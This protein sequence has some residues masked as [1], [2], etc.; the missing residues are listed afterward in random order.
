MKITN[1]KKFMIEEGVN[2]ID[3]IVME[4]SS[5]FY[6]SIEAQ[7][8]MKFNAIKKAFEFHYKHSDFYKTYCRE[9]GNITPDDIQSY[10]DLSKIPVIPNSFFQE[11]RSEAMLSLP[12]EFK[13]LEFHTEG[14]QGRHG[15]AYRD[16]VSNEYA[17]IGLHLLFEE[18]MDLRQ[19]GSPAALFLT[20]SIAD[21]PNLGMLRAL[22]ILNSIFTVQTYAMENNQFDFVKASEFIKK[23]EGQLPIFI[24]GPPFIVNFFIEFLKANKIKFNLNENA[25]IMTAGGWKRSTGQIVSKD[26]L[27]QK[28][29]DTFGVKS[30]QYRDLFGLIELNQFSME[31]WA[32]KKHIPP[33]CEFFIKDL[34]DPS[35]VCEDGKEGFVTIL[36]PT[37]LTYPGF[38][39]TPDVGTVYHN[40]HCE[41]GR[42]SSIINII[43]R[44]QK[45]EDINCSITLDKYLEGK[46]EK[47]KH[48]Y[49]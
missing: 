13:Q 23:W 4:S 1:L 39:R 33:F 37:V 12:L 46:S 31:C 9:S 47:L 5:M 17:I 15:V 14:V 27:T 6:Y 29:C 16:S 49:S 45:A 38:I 36:D 48:S 20:P 10:N 18:L 8:E 41:C 35:K 34:N 7:T 25:R 26:D 22:A 28:I 11:G 24:I 30:S 2:A 42:T 43:G 19:M 3:K 21:A 44:E 40:Y 32:H